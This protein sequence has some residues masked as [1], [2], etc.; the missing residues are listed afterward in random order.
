MDIII[1]INCDNAAFEEGYE[2]YYI[3]NKIARDERLRL[4][5][6][7]DCIPILDSNGNR[8]GQLEVE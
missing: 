3:L 2:V 6:P 7:G 8:V 4:A 1:M 5:S